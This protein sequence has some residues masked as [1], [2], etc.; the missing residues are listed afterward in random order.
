M[1]RLDRFGQGFRRSV[2][3]VT[4]RLEAFLVPPAT[5][6]REPTNEDY[7]R[8][9]LLVALPAV[10]FFVPSLLIAGVPQDL[11]IPFTVAA[12]ATAMWVTAMFLYVPRTA[13]VAARLA[14]TSNALVVAAL[15]WFFRDYYHEVMLLYLLLIAAHAV[16]HGLVPALFGVALS[17]LIIPFVL[18]SPAAGNWTDPFYAALYSSGAALIPWVAWRFGQ[19]RAELLVHLRRESETERSSLAA[20]LA[21]MSDAVIAVDRGGLPVRTNAAYDRLL[22]EVPTMA[23]PDD[24]HGSRLPRSRW[25]QVRA[26]RGDSFSTAFTAK[27]DAGDRRWFEATGGPIGGHEGVVGGIVVI[28]DI[29]DRSLRRLQ[30]EFMATA[31]HE[32]RTPVAALHGYVQLLERHVDPQVNAEAAGYARSALS[33][34]RRVGRLLDRLFDLA[35]LQTGALEVE[36]RRFDLVSTVRAAVDA[37]QALTSDQ[38][39]HLRVDGESLDVIGDSG[40]TEEVLLNVLTN[41][42]THASESKRIDV[43]VSRAGDSAK[44]E[45]QDRGPGISPAGLAR[46]FTRYSRAKRRAGRGPA[47][48]GLGLHI[49]RELMRAQG[50]TIEV[51]SVLGAG[52]TVTIRLPLVTGTAPRRR[53]RPGPGPRP[54]ALETIAR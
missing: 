24:D 47:G 3:P 6:P 30:E 19:Q 50:G 38:A 13:T 25:P 31:S 11:W 36:L 15:G 8:V 52:T 21:S 35:R 27:T 16:V 4:D 48:L 53:R 18:Q 28:R 44:V 42:V 46:V 39:F 22:A 40:R 9:V 43:R 2:R 12:L 23:A 37:A 49:S 51:R 26:A 20:I 29:T 45:V 34:T 41:A 10:G 7:R 33:Q 17:P 54:P 32:L 1:R 5:S 14:A